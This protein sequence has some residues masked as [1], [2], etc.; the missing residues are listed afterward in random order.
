MQSGVR[1]VPGR[2]ALR[3]GLG[4]AGTSGSA[5]EVDNGS[6][7]RVSRQRRHLSAALDWERLIRTVARNLHENRRRQLNSSDQGGLP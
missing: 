6:M 4:G 2:P 3:R 5:N 7:R 1:P